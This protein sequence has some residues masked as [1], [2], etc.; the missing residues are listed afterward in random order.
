MGNQVLTAEDLLS[1]IQTDPKAAKKLLG[2]ALQARSYHS[3]EAYGEYVHGFAPAPHQQIWCEALQKASQGIEE[4]NDEENDIC[5]V[6]PPGHGKTNWIIYY[7][8]WQLGRRPDLHI[9]YVTN[10]GDLAKNASMA[11]RDTIKYSAKHRRVFPDCLPDPS[12]E[13]AATSWYLQREQISDKNPSLYA[14]GVE[15]SIIGKRFD[16][17]ILDDVCDQAN[18]AT[19]YQRDKVR[20]WINQTVFSRLIK[21]G[22]IVICIMTRWHEMDVM[23]L[24]KDRGGFQVIHMPSLGFWEKWNG[25][26]IANLTDGEALWPEWITRK[27]LLKE[28][29]S[30]PK[31][32]DLMYQGLESVE[33][34]EIFNPK[35]WRYYKDPP[36]S[37]EIELIIQIID[38]AFSADQDSDYTVIATW[39][40]TKVGAFLFDLIRGRVEFLDLIRLVKM[41]YQEYHPAALFIEDAGSGKSLVQ[42]LQSTT[43]MPV[44]GIPVNN[45][46]KISRAH[47]STGLIKAGK[48]FLPIDAPWLNTF[49]NEHSIFPNGAYD[50]QVDTTSMALTIIQN[51]PILE[52]DL[53]V[54]D[55]TE[56]TGDLVGEI[57][58]E[59]DDVG[60][61][62]IPSEF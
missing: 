33:D 44:E 39:A 36:N 37:L 6:A 47:A 52:D 61:G 32:F 11:I 7:C 2:Q 53:V 60:F 28:R 23:K 56:I 35:Y 58:M 41:K 50:D 1:Q 19:E 25:Q 13:W 55:A 49:V 43:R 51:L 57:G 8:A 21:K 31:M 38:T 17:V 20:E 26:E 45:K 3:L 9:G 4:R 54:I 46:S 48:V 22:G 15:G 40:I 27:N 12:K 24:L 18:Q 42:T 29:N 62:T 14:A 59:Y 5:L 16:I 30:D 10:T 34:G